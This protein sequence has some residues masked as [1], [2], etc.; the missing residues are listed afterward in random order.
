MIQANCSK[1]AALFSC[2]WAWYTTDI[3]N[4]LELWAWFFPMGGKKRSLIHAWNI[5]YYGNSKMQTFEENPF[6]YTC[7][8][9]FRGPVTVQCEIFVH[10][11]IF[12]LLQGI[13][14]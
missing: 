12:Q 8:E 5:Q 6:S 13:P 4:R 11:A 7:K 3:Y 1:Q 14:L 10:T 2:I 9:C